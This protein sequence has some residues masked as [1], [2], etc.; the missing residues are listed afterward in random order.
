MRKRRKSGDSRVLSAVVLVLG[1]LITTPAATSSPTSGSSPPATS[2]PTVT[3]STAPS[4]ALASTPLY[5]VGGIGC[6]GHP[7]QE[8]AGTVTLTRDGDSLKVD[9]E[10]SD[11]LYPSRTFTVEAWEEAPGCYPD[12]AL[13]VP[14]VGLSTNSSG[15]GSTSFTLALPWSR[16][17]P[18]GS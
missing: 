5:R 2:S 8:Q 16:L 7:H 15:S 17:F 18:D 4:P 9:V 14:G 13:R 10:V 11:T 1:W 3:S 6:D 12:N